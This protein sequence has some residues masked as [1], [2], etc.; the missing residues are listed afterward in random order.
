MKKLF[1]DT[2]IY[3]SR[4]L[5]FDE[6]N[7][8]IKILIDCAQKNKFV[9]L[10]LSVIDNEILAHLK[11][12]GAE[13]EKNLKKNHKW[14]TKYINDVEIYNNCYKDLIDY[15]KFKE[16][17]KA[18]N[19]NVSKID[20]EVILKKYFDVELPFEKK[21]VKKNEFPDAFIAEYI[22]DFVVN[23]KHDEVIF[24]SQDNGLMK[25]I[26]ED[27]KKYSSIE[28]FLMDLNGVD[29]NKYS[30]I[31]HIITDNLTNISSNILNNLE[32]D[33]KF[34]DEEEIEPT[35]VFINN[36]FDFY[37][38][39]DSENTISVS[40]TFKELHLSGNFTCLDYDNSYWPNDEDYYTYIEYIKSEDI[41][42]EDVN[43]EFDIVKDGEDFIIEY[44]GKYTLDIDFNIIK[45]NAT[46]HYF[47][48]EDI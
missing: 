21:E 22:N 45:E 1:I 15:E 28:E 24:V 19:C 5:N 47:S 35:G 32:L 18:I 12:R 34:I 42:Y 48:L 38:I 44:D 4:G 11:K 7:I 14:I 25:S 41:K 36:D 17:I 8:I 3:D 37:V 20:S 13:S 46:E 29:V 43:I 10:N 2:N 16:S 9:Y 40:C 23:N 39:D 30:F 26:S 6:K 27:V 33:I 31:N